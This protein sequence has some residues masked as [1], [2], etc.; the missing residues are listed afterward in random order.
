M[1]HIMADRRRSR[2][3]SPVRGRKLDTFELLHA[4]LMVESL[5]GHE[6]SRV[7]SCRCLNA[8]GH[9]TPNTKHPFPKSELMPVI[10]QGFTFLVGCGDHLWGILGIGREGDEAEKDEKDEKEEKE[11]VPLSS[12]LEAGLIC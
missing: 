10:S 2:S 5:N 6:A 8:L 12:L 7:F 4:S 11:K 1:A 3:R 9:E